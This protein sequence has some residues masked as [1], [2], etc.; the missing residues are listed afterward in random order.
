MS[1]LA[2]YPDD[3]TTARLISQ[4]GELI[5]RE[6][7]ARGV[8]FERWPARA[9]LQADADSEAILAAYATEIALVQAEGGYGTVDAIRLGPDHPD[10]LALRQKFLAEHTH[11]EDEVRFFVEGRGL[12]CLHLGQEVLQLIC[13]RN[14]WISVPAGTRHWFDMGPEPSFCALRFFDNTEGWVAR[15]SGDA[16]AARYP[17]LDALLAGTA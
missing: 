7:A 1:L 11:A 17:K 5:Q 8:R 15:F 13:E 6:L 4:D 2:I 12:F 16:I 3:T 10:R 9:D 14:D